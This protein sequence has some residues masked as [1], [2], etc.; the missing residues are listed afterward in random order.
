M[1][2]DK[3]QQIIDSKNEQRERQVVRT[4]EDLIENIILEQKKIEASKER[5][6]ELRAELKSLEVATI[7]ASAILGD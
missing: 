2:Q 4:A 5:I 3:L 6:D 1:N 7:N